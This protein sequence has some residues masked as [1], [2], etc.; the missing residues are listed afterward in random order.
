MIWLCVTYTGVQV[1]VGA[2]CVPCGVVFGVGVNPDAKTTTL[3]RQT[4]GLG[5]ISG[6][7]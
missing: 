1:L 4:P 5:G 6:H 3:A 2:P 7:V